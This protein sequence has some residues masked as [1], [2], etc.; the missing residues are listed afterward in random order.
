M[1]SA[2]GV[3]VALGSELIA[4]IFTMAFQWEVANIL[5]PTQFGTMGMLLAS[6]AIVFPLADLGLQS[7]ALRHLANSTDGRAFGDILGLRLAGSLVYLLAIPFVAW[8][9]PVEQGGIAGLYLAGG[10]YL[11]LSVSEFLRQVFRA[12]ELTSLEFVS[13]LALPL[14]MVASVAL[15]FWTRS[16]LN[17][18]LALYSLGP[19]AL[20]VSYLFGL[21]RSGIVPAL[22]WR[23]ALRLLRGEWPAMLQTM[24]HIAAVN[25]V[26]RV[27]LW[28]LDEN[29]S[30]AV[31]GAYLAG[32]NMVFAG[33]FFAQASSSYFYP[34]LVREGKSRGE[35]LLKVLLAQGALAGAMYLGV[36][37]VASRVFHL[38][39]RTKGY[40]I[41]VDYLPYFGVLI[42]FSAM[43]MVWFNLLLARKIQ[44]WYALL[45]L[46]QVG[47]KLWLGG[48]FVQ[49]YGPVGMARLSVMIEIPS[50]IF[51]GC[52][53]SWVFMRKG[54]TSE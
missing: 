16:G 52:V 33:T 54:R 8:K 39:Y 15:M 35:R 47:L 21:A 51:M 25:L 22:D 41:G 46:A 14:A 10:Y 3:G 44:G 48:R 17:G 29:A 9:F 37:L 40:E 49:E 13:R 26:M 42:A 50:S 20:V 6:A 53:A 4:R 7:L 43:N 24:F 27:D 18:A 30:R 11:L 45:V 38:I 31:V 19:A 28:I 32:Y 2:T 5:G 36:I 12:K 1:R 23:R 34:Y